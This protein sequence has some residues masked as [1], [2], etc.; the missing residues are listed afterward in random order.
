MDLLDR[1]RFAA[2]GKYEENQHPNM[3][4][5]GF[6]TALSGQILLL[7]MSMKALSELSRW[8][9]SFLDKWLLTFKSQK[10]GLWLNEAFQKVMEK[11]RS[12]AFSKH[13]KGGWRLNAADTPG[14][15]ASWA[16]KGC[17]LPNSNSNAY[18]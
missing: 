11:K 18:S 15:V 4:L 3:K 1:T 17:R 10:G 6:V 12:G 9:C 7:S 2:P 8:L 16:P 14:E 13:L 5:T